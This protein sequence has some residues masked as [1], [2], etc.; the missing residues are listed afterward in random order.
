MFT[1]Y[2][3]GRYPDGDLAVQDDDGY[4]RITGRHKDMIIRGGENV[5]PREIEE[6]LHRHPAVEDVQVV[7]IPDERFGEAV[8]A[9]I[10]LRTGHEA[11]EEEIRTFLRASLAHFKV[12]KYIDF[13]TSFPMTV[14]GKVQKFRIREVAAQEHGLERV[15]PGVSV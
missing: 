14:T 11:T 4:V 13:V 1:V 9:W 2:R 8:C 10:K 5:Y 12:P 7:G 3:G 6:V 15:Q